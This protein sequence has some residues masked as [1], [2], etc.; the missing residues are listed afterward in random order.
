MTIAPGFHLRLTQLLL[1][2]LI[3]LQ[4]LI[5]GLI[6]AARLGDIGRM[7]DGSALAQVRA[8]AAL[9]ESLPP[10]RRGVALQALNSPLLRYSLVDAYDAL[11]AADREG[12]VLPGLL[13]AARREVRTI[14]PMADSEERLRGPFARPRFAFAL[15]LS[16]GA[17]L[18]VEPSRFYRRRALL[19][20]AAL[21]STA[22]AVAVAAGLAFSAAATARPLRRMA[23]EAETFAARLD[24]PPMPETGP[25]AVATLA[26]SFNRM[27]AALRRL[28]EERT[29]TLA[30]AAHDLRTYLTRL[31]MRV[32]DIGDEAQREKAVRDIEEM[33]QL[34]D[35]ALL[36][37]R[38]A[39]ASATIER[40]DLNDLVQDV[41]SG[42]REARENVN[43][44]APDA[45]VFVDADRMLLRRGLAN[46]VDNAIR[47]GDAAHVEIVVSAGRVIVAVRDNGA[48]VPEDAIGALSEPFFRIETSR[49]RQTGGAGLGLSIA[50]AAA[51]QAGGRLE[52]A[53]L[54]S[55]G[56]EARIS[57]PLAAAPS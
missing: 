53:N 40:V 24:A 16:D 48:G 50:R 26:R 49:S 7:G 47:Y 22:L 44:Q 1:F 23:A 5:G 28:V 13:Q 29:R 3:A 33:S 43:L 4:I 35:D 42:W 9:V 41:L 21:A 55:G 15:R 54:P 38:K 52:L 19:N 25:P 30:A 18:V 31:R 6:V 17:G 11:P 14:E 2:A 32:E 39:H 12:R 36:A 56:L 34:I 46:L 20:L 37:A 45:A 8:A 57:L 51:E 27:K 10:E